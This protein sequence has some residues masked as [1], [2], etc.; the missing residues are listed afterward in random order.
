MTSE[1]TQNIIN[2]AV[3][4]ATYKKVVDKINNDFAPETIKYNPCIQSAIIP[5]DIR[6]LFLS[7]YSYE[8]NI[9]KISDYAEPPVYFNRYKHINFETFKKNEVIYNTYKTWLAKEFFQGETLDKFETDITERIQYYGHN[10]K[11]YVVEG[12]DHREFKDDNEFV[13]QK[14]NLTTNTHLILYYLKLENCQSNCGTKIKYIDNDKNEKELI[15]QADDNVVYCIRDGCFAHN[16]PISIPITMNSP[17]NRILVRSYV[18]PKGRKFEKS[19]CP[20]FVKW[21]KGGKLKKTKNHKSRKHHTR[22]LRNR[23]KRKSRLV[24]RP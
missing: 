15:L 22:T 11:S 5:E 12:D 24:K 2:T 6:Q 19:L 23:R 16:T 20:N 21:G 17:I 10:E 4:R 18:T 8:K 1:I 7:E 3:N 14:Q 13:Q 9:E